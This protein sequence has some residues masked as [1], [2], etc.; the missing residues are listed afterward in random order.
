MGERKRS[1]EEDPS[2]KEPLFEEKAVEETRYLSK[3]E[4]VRD[5]EYG[6]LKRLI[7]VNT[8]TIFLFWS[9]PD[10]CIG[11]NF[12][13]IS[14]DGRTAN[15]GEILGSLAV[16]ITRSTPL[17][18]LPELLPVKSQTKISAD[19][20]QTYLLEEEVQEDAVTRLRPANERDVT[21]E[22]KN[23]EFKLTESSETSTLK[24]IS[25]QLAK[26]QKVGICGMVG[27][28][29]VEPSVTMEG[30][31]AYVAHSSWIQ[32]G[33]GRAMDRRRYELCCLQED[34]ELFASGDQTVIGERGINMSGG[35]KQ[36]IQ[37]ARACTKMQMFI[38]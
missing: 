9:F 23:G 14:S 38:Y 28:R 16:F 31:T 17:I 29:K 36:R 13:N 33:K 6:W 37:L 15:Y 32:S 11:G 20:L 1:A 30:T 7:Y 2:M 21:V 4:K 19:W 35:Q 26:W 8:G 3:L 22:V 12:R 27:T 34:M 10:I 25:F 18:T 5:V 24:D